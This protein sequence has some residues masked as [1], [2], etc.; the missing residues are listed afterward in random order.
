[1]LAELQSGNF[2]G[3]TISI[4]VNRRLPV[5]FSDFSII[6]ETPLLKKINF[7]SPGVFGPPEYPGPQSTSDYPTS[8]PASVHAC[9]WS[10]LFFLLFV[11]GTWYFPLPPRVAIFLV[12]P[13]GLGLPDPNPN[14]IPNPKN[15]NFI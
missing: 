10:L 11:M 5:I 15:V 2:Y 1:M 12:C 4:P 13:L 6:R 8:Q 3:F 14:A 7:F 9:F